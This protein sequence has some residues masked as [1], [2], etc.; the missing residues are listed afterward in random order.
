MYSVKPNKRRNLISTARFSGGLKL[1]EHSRH[2]LYLKQQ[3]CICEI[4]S[5]LRRPNTVK[6]AVDRYKQPYS[7]S[8]S[9]HS[10]GRHLEI[11]YCKGRFLVLCS[12]KA[13]SCKLLKPLKRSFWQSCPW[14]YS[15]LSLK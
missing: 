13:T 6:T 10:S 15:K 3:C 4:K 9:P 14:L 11:Y 7:T 1:P 8:C 2:Y 12:S 5:Y